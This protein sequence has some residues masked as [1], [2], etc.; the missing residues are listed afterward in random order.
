[1]S[2]GAHRVSPQIVAFCSGRAGVGKSTTL[3]NLAWTAA[4]DGIRCLL[5]DADLQAPSLHLLFGLNPIATAADAYLGTVPIESVVLPVRPGLYLVPER[6][7]TETAQTQLSSV[8]PTLLSRLLGHLHPELVL[9]DVSPG[10]S[11]LIATIGGLSTTCAIVIADDIGS[12]LDA[13]GLLKILLGGTTPPPKHTGL[14]FTYTLDEL[15]AETIAVK[16]NAVVQRFLGRR[17]PMLGSIPYD[18]QHRD[19]LLQQQL[20]AELFPQ[21]PTTLAYRRLLTALVSRAEK[22]SHEPTPLLEP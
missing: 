18:P 21:A 19:A 17:L 10:W 6:A 2:Q 14:V 16:L 8:F 5:W 15:D 1:M 20:F 3:A 11:E 13:Y 12:I 4:E 7:G 9:L 22:P